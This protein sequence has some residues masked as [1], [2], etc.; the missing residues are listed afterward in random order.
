MGRLDMA[1]NVK[2]IY[3][4]TKVV[5]VDFDGT[6]F[7]WDELFADN[8]PLPGAV[9]AM[10]ELRSMGYLIYIFSSR[11]SDTWVMETDQDASVHH[12]HM[13]RLL[14]KYQ[15]PHDGF[16]WDKIP[17]RFYI[18]D[19]AI[20]FRGFWEDTILTLKHIQAQED[21]VGRDNVRLHGEG[22]E[23]PVQAGEQSSDCE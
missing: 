5:A 14:K 8:P 15:V 12:A 11:L 9:D 17:A 7:P 13:E 2:P 19:R 21:E 1:H 4:Y 3:D 20:G 18:D 16:A 6:L 22:A 23:E 10:Q